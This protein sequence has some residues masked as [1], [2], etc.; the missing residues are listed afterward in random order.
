MANDLRAHAFHPKISRTPSLDET[1]KRENGRRHPLT[2]PSFSS[3]REESG[4]TRGRRA[5]NL[6]PSLPPALL[7]IVEGESGEAADVRFG[8]T[9]PVQ[10]VEPLPRGRVVGVKRGEIKKY[11]VFLNGRN[12]WIKVD[13]H[14]KRKGFYTTRFVEA[15]TAKEAKT[16]AVELVRSEPFLR[17]AVKNDKSNPPM[18]YLEDIETVPSFEGVGQPGAGHTWYDQD[19]SAKG[20]VKSSGR[21][22]KRS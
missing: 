7:F 14:L 13:G 6:R 9:P 5:A 18:I 16:L 8:S 11:K 4:K 12:F 22:K 2:A 10:C 20:K 1:G 21:S 19:S 15:K 17:A 3:D